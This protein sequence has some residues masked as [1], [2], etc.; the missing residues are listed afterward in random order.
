MNGVLAVSFIGMQHA[1][2]DG[3]IAWSCLILK[4]HH[5]Q[6]MNFVVQDDYLTR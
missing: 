2:Y 1:R 6:T 5:S 4:V 3:N